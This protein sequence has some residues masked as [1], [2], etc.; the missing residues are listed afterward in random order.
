[1]KSVQTVLGTCSSEELGTTLMHEHVLVGLPGWQFDSTAPLLNR[2]EAIGVAVERVQELKSYRV[3]TIVDPCPTDFGRDAEFIREVSQRSGMRIICSAGLFA[4]PPYQSQ[5]DVEHLAE[6]YIKEAT[7]GIGR[8]GVKPGI[9]KV[10]TQQ[11]VTP[12]EEK[13][14]HAIGKAAKATGL[15]ITTHTDNASQ[16]EK[17][18]DVFEQ[19]GVSPKRV[20]IGHSDG[21]AD[22]SYHVGLMERGAFLG[23]DRWGLEVYIQDKLRLASLIGLVGIGYANQIVLSH[24]SICCWLGKPLL[25][26][27]LDSPLYANWH[28]TYL[29]KQ[30]IP[31][32]KDAGVGDE[33]VRAM[34]VDNP[35]RLFQAE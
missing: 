29:F 17:Q 25:N 18:L 23:F 9:F 1:M 7:D 35:R 12:I 22:L 19:E 26:P 6:I 31:R 21:R 33:A 10:A 4:L 28:P 15:P 8:T 13:N 2:D 20:V 11:T 32:L 16:G 34:L 5:L 24:D 14:L 30:I 27:P 3:E